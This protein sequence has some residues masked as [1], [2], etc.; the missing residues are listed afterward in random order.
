VLVAS[1]IAATW[2]ALRLAR[3]FSILALRFAF[4]PVIV[5]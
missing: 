1:S 4:M 5:A 3:A 2:A